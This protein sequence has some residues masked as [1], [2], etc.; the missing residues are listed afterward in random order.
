MRTDDLSRSTYTASSFGIAPDEILSPG[1]DSGSD[2]C[3]LPTGP[4]DR[5]IGTGLVF[6]KSYDPAVVFLGMS[7][8]QGL[9]IDPNA[10]RRGLA[11]H[12]YG[13]VLGYTYAVNDTLALNS[14]LSGSYRD[15]RPADETAIPAARERYQLQLGM[16]WSLARG[17]YMEPSTSFRVGSAA[18]DFTFATNVHYSF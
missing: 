3:V 16:T 2:S 1:R 6:A 10:S 14:S 8:M 9:K 13:L 12:N 15:S 7:Y 18:P 17:L 11:A 4:G 5:G